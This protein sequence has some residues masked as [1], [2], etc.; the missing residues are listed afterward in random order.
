M[1][2]NKIYPF[3]LTST[4]ILSNEEYESDV[5]RLSGHQ[6]GIARSKLE[7]KA[8]KQANI[9]AAALAQFIVENTDQDIDD[10]M[11]P[12]SIAALLKNAVKKPT[13]NIVKFESSGTYTP[14]PGTQ[15][16][17]VEGVGGGGGGGGCTTG[18][19]NYTSLGAGGGSG[20]YCKSKINIDSLNS[21]VSVTI[22][23]G[24]SGNSAVN[25]SAGGKTIFGSFFE[26]YG[27]DGGI[28]AGPANGSIAIGGSVGG[29][30]VGANL[31]NIRGDTGGHAFTTYPNYTLGGN[32]GSGI[33]GS[34]GAY[35]VRA[36]GING[37][38]Y[39]AGGGGS[40][41]SGGALGTFKG[42]N[43]APGVVII[44]EYILY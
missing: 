29:H 21:P 30:A 27:G 16:I 5:Q 19:A 40:E 1:A 14:T 7:N 23:A 26:A 28:K 17:I 18:T 33:L 43:G 6:P 44:T 34:G 9:M 3:G 8:L 35:S 36:N 12:K 10:S 4:N 42:G 38:G 13:I 22:G 39:G 11:T 2:E 41:V 37:T 25:G 32:G 20:G 31:L 24:G 15:F